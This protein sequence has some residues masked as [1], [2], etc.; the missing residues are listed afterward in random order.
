MWYDNSI[1]Q[2]AKYWDKPWV[3]LK[4]NYEANVFQAVCVLQSQLQTITAKSLPHAL[5]ENF[6]ISP[7]PRYE[8]TIFGP[9]PTVERGKGSKA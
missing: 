8:V 6:T 3:T 2:D 4:E 7:T 1:R 5:N 9:K